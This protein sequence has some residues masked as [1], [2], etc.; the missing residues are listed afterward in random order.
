MKKIFFIV[1]L[2]FLSSTFVSAQIPSQAEMDKLIKQSQDLLKQY[3]GDTMVKK[4]LKSAEEQQKQI[5]GA[6]KTSPNKPD[7]SS[8]NDPGAYGNVDNWKFPPRN[9]ALLST[10][11]KGIL[12]KAQ[13]V[14]FLSDLYGQLSKKLTVGTA[15]SVQTIAAKYMNNADKMG[16]A[17]VIGWYNDHEE[18][19]ILLIIKAAATN[20]DNE[21]LLNN[22]AALLT[23]GGIE[24]K[25]IPIL[26]YILQSYPENSMVLN[27][28]GQAY[29]G[30]GET[31]TAMHYFMR[32]MRTEPENA[33]ACGT[34]GQIEAT[35]GNIE[36]A[37]E[38]L[39]KSLKSAYTKTA[40]LKLRKLRKGYRVSR[41]V[42]P[43]VK[44][45]EYFNLFKYDLPAQCIRVEDAMKSDA[46]HNAFRTMVTRQANSFGV[47]YQELVQKEYQRAMEM[48]NTGARGRHLHPDEFMAQPFHEFCTIM[49]GDVLSEFQDD[50]TSLQNW[51]KNKFTP[52]Y[53]TLDAEYRGRLKGLGFFATEKER[54][55]AENALANEFLP[56]FAVAMEELQERH[57][58]IYRQYFDELVYWHFLSLH[59]I[60]KDKARMRQIEFILQYLNMLG[61]VCQTKII[62]HC[63]F[64]SFTITKESN[65]IKKYECPL[66]IEIPFIIGSFSLD[67]D[68]VSFSAGEGA[69][70]G[71]EKNFKT[72]ISTLSVG[73]GAKLE[74]GKVKLGPA[75]AKLSASAGETL[76][77]TFDGDNKVSDAGLKF[78]V[79]L[80]AG[81][82]IKGSKEI[83]TDKSIEV[84][85]DLGSKDVSVGYTF[86]ISSGFTF[87]EGPFKGMVK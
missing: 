45:P 33:E 50:L 61:G 16:D 62:K 1:L 49:A 51:V 32:C 75:E 2:Y 26:K 42:R 22:C 38:Y 43:R 66:E 54:C 53:A 4:A 55:N 83:A 39:E 17:A 84:K 70:F 34:A 41:L 59:P 11:P 8:N 23:M 31:D 72:K 48:M 19:S 5:A 69:I 58:R 6:I 47:I 28:L 13:L 80:G 25:A 7:A 76:F 57:L 82:E 60:D 74:L 71:Y 81:A 63:D 67:C 78:G 29:A 21:L 14:S 18:E 77:I 37:V 10:L 79:K 86:G 40:A 87:N 56:R 65:D 15:A 85:R 35:K 46:E 36:K 68:K 30:L 27:N 12:T 24:H 20:P 9:I 73:I 44:L 52:E 64:K 3:G